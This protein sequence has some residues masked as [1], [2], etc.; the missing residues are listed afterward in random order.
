M[1]PLYRRGDIVSLSRS[2]TSTIRVLGPA[3]LAGELHRV[4]LN[5]RVFR[6][7]ARLGESP[8]DIAAGVLAQLRLQTV[9]SSAVDGDT[10]AL[11]GERGIPFELDVSANLEAVRVVESVMGENNELWRVMKAIEFW[12][13]DPVTRETIAVTKAT[14]RMLSGSTV[15]D[16]FDTEIQ[17]LVAGA[18]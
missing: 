11:V 8:E 18:T 5:G 7:E 4:E 3:Q 2:Q 17:T 6:Y 12:T 9:V 10:V 15:R 13:R 16:F 1:A 14:A